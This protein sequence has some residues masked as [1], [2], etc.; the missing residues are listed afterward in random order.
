MRSTLYHVPGEAWL[1]TKPMDVSDGS[2]S[3]PEEE[4]R[5]WCLHELLRS[6]GVCITNI[7]I[8]WPVKVGRRVH[9]ADIVVL[10]DGHPYIVI[11]CKASGAQKHDE[12]MRQ[13]ISYAT[14]ADVDAEFAV[15][16]NGT[17]WWVRR[18]IRGQWVPVSDI[19]LF[20]DGSPSIDWR[21]ALLAVDRLAPILFWLDKVVPAKLAPRYFGALQRFFY[22]NNEVTAGTDRKLLRTAEHVL[23]VLDDA[24]RH[25]GYTCGKMAQACDSL[26]SYWEKRGVELSFGADDFGEM[27]HHAW[28]HLSNQ[29]DGAGN[30]VSLDHQ[31]LRVIQSLL[32]YLDEMQVRHVRYQDVEAAIQDEIRAYIDLAL[33]IRFNARLPDIQDCILIGD[34]HELCEP[35]WD[36][37]LKTGQK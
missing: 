37:Y 24:T 26:N 13:A 33:A 1:F 34:I 4:V 8:E 35:A 17:L 15:Y 19:P 30:V 29:I 9:R 31:A 6:Y 10:R 12:A 23:R 21:D 20:R 32:R 7:E 11:E 14:A 2:K 5:Q 18:R 36:H 22:A 25:S 3:E 27:A 28:A 16:T